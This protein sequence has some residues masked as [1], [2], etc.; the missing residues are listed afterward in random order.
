MQPGECGH[1]HFENPSRELLPEFPKKVTQ[2]RE[3]IGKK[4]SQ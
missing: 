3:R 2:S 4:G 1:V